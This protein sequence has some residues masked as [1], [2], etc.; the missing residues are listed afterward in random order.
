MLTV[1]GAESCHLLEEV[2]LSLVICRPVDRGKEEGGPCAE[3][4][5]RGGYRKAADVMVGQRHD[6]VVP[7]DR[8]AASGAVRREEEDV[9][10]IGASNLSR[11]VCRDVLK[12]RFLDTEDGRIRG[13]GKLRNHVAACRGVE[14]SRVPSEDG[15]NWFT[16]G[17][18]WGDSKEFR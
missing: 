1:G 17:G 14:P 4:G 12:L 3:Y 11:N 6:R 16:H 10:A 15:A 5:D 2:W 18:N 8:H 9:A 13:V 7:E